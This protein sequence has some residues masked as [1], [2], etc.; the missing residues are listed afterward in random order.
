MSAPEA[1]ETEGEDDEASSEAVSAEEALEVLPDD[2]E[3][4]AEF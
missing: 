1:G 4:E 2:D 3:F